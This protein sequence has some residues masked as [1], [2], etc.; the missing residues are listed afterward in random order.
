MLGSAIV[1]SRI[2]RLC[3]LERASAL[4]TASVASHTCHMYLRGVVTHLSMGGCECVTLG[5]SCWAA[6]SSSSSSSSSSCYQSSHS[7]N[8]IDPAAAKQCCGSGNVLRPQVTHLIHTPFDL[9][10]C[11]MGAVSG[12]KWIGTAVFRRRTRC[13]TFAQASSFVWHSRDSYDGAHACVFIL[14][15]GRE[16]QSRC[17]A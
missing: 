2:S 15:V 11:V 4:C 9:S 3:A 5:L 12:S 6:A 10:H 13:I 8:A 14:Q 1:L 17:H 16:R 7:I